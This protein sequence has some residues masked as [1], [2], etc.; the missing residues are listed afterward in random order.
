MKTL[1]LLSPGPRRLATALALAAL[2][3]TS[4]RADNWEPNLTSTI[5]W[6]T[7]VT[8]TDLGADQDDALQLKLDLLAAQRYPMGREDSLQLGLHL[9]G[10]FWPRYNGLS[11]ALGGGSAEWAH[12]FGPNAH[13]FELSLTGAVDAVAAKETGRRGVATSATLAL[14][15]RLD[16]LTR[17][18]AGYEVSWLEARY[19]TF[20]RAAGEA[21]V[22]LDRDLND[23]TRLTLSVRFRD[24]D[25]LSYSEI[26]RA[27]LAAL[28]PHNTVVGTFGSPMTAYR[29]DAHTWTGRLSVARALDQQSAVVVGYEFRD[30]SRGSFSFRNHVFSAAFVFQF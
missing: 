5:V 18:R 24:G 10:S 21:L 2:T 13:A 3:L 9:G 22:D 30:T 1:R 23:V 29:I 12:K 4:L 26:P 7:N 20:D 27:D 17:I 19:Q 25:V 6:Q 15:K 28:A 14:R 8:N 11:E 16:D